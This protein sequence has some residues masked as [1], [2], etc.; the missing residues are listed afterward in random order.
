MFI[1]YIRSYPQYLEALSSTRNLRTR[2]AMVTKDPHI[3]SSGLKMKEDATQFS[4]FSPFDRTS[5]P[6]LSPSNEPD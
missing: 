1:Q 6:T 2:H 4:P 5:D 3:P